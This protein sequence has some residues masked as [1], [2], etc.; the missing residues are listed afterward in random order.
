MTKLFYIYTAKDGRKFR[1][2][3]YPEVK[4]LVARKGGKYEPRYEKVNG[5]YG[6]APDEIAKKTPK[7]Q[8]L[9]DRDGAIIPT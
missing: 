6:E 3:T 1:V 4:D 5:F 9:L 8:V 7:R 2:A